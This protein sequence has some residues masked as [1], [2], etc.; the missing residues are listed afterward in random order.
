LARFGLAVNQVLFYGKAGG[1]WVG[2]DGFTVTDPS[3]GISFTAQAVNTNSGWLVG[4]GFEWAFADS[5]SAKLAYDFFGIEQPS[6]HCSGGVTFLR[7]RHV[8]DRQSQRSDGKRLG[9]TT[10]SIGEARAP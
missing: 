6:I 9:S 10:A 5:W 1:G 3:T 2:A 4:A 7:G 8:H